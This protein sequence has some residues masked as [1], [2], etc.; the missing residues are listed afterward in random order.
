MLVVTG[1]KSPQIFG[2]KQTLSAKRKTEL[3]TNLGI[4][5]ID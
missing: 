4:E 5:F 3:S 1:V 2:P